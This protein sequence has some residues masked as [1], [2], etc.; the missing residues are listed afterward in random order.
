M[1]D[2][3]RDTAFYFGW[4]GVAGAVLA[5]L[6]LAL[7][8]ADAPALAQ[9]KKSKPARQTRSEKAAPPSSPLADAKEALVNATKEYKASL[10]TL[11]SMYEG[12]VR[13][14]EERLSQ[15]KELQAAG[16]ISKR[17]LEQNEHAVADAQARVSEVRGRIATAE[18]Q[19]AEALVEADADA[20]MAKAP[21]VPVGK[22]VRATS[23]I[24]YNAPGAWSLSEA[25]RVQRFFQEK[26]GRPLPISAFGQS[27]VHDRWR[28]DH[29]NSMD[30]PLNPDGSE[31]QALMTFLRSNGIPF[32]AFRGA[33]PG[34][35]TGPH[36]HV[37]RP[38]HKF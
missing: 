17:D 25:W 30:V 19:I 11:L 21:P 15:S 22:L 20:Q 33:I 10:E 13:K 24:R 12:N 23:Y 18:T 9:R 35:A 16:L 29:H 36:I 38:S 34:A 1:K 8:T 3:S 6:C 37:G 27:A 28:L 31:G 26:F 14:A 32:S 7:I 2:A 5:A 4:P